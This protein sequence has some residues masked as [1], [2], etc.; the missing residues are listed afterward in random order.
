MIPSIIPNNR[1]KTTYL[2]MCSVRRRFHILLRIVQRWFD[3]LLV[4]PAGDERSNVGR[5]GSGLQPAQE[6]SETLGIVDEQETQI[7][8]RRRNGRRRWQ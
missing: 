4:A 5:N 6:L 7:G 3:P 8:G 2:F 1:N